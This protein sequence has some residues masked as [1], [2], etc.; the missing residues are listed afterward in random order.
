MSEYKSLKYAPQP[1]TML[2]GSRHTLSPN[3]ISVPALVQKL[4]LLLLTFFQKRA[5]SS[6]AA[7]SISTFNSIWNFS[8]HLRW[9][10]RNKHFAVLYN[11]FMLCRLPRCSVYWTCFRYRGIH[12]HRG[13]NHRFGMGLPY[14]GQKSLWFFFFLKTLVFV[15][16]INTCFNSLFLDF[17]NA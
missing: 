17:D 12:Y 15:Q 16:R 6:S 2:S 1:E 10:A 3:L 5:L 7:W 13:Y 4:F 11:L 8:A 14:M 9:C